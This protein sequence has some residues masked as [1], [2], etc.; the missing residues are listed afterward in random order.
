MAA[1]T[2]DV[3]VL[4]AGPGGYVA[5]I[6]AAQLGLKVAC[7]EA[8]KLGGVCNNLGCIP[9]K[10]LLESAMYARR[11]HELGDFGIRVSEVSLDLGAAGK[12]AKKVA[13][14]G[15]KGVAFLFKKNNVEWVKGWGRLA[16]KGKVSVKGSDGE[17]T[18]EAKNIILATGSRPKD[19][20]ILKADGD[21]V[22]NSD[23]AVFPAGAP[24]SLAVIGGGAVG[25]EFADVYA[26]FGTK[27]TVIEAL[28]RV[29]PLEDKDA[30]AAVA[31]SY[32]K[33]GMDVLEGARLE[34][35]DVGKA[36]VKL[37]VKAKDGKTNTIEVER[38]L[39]AV[40]RAPIIEDIG[41]ESAGV[42]VDKGFIAV[43]AQLRTSAPGIFAIGDVAR[44]PLL[45]H[46]ASHEGIAVVETIAGHAHVVDTNN[47]PNVTYCHPEVASVGLTED[48][49]RAQGLEVEI[50]VFPFSANG[51]ARTAGESE[52]FVKV[53]RDR[54]Y[55]ELLG[56]HIVGPH[57][58][59][60]IAEFVLGR[61][62]ESTAEELERAMHPHPTLSEAVAEAALAALGRAI[63][64]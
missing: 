15:A 22:W 50:G 40:G 20:P 63:H 14:Q 19:L 13:D 55:S 35:A 56:A 21:R 54:R 26:S 18:L 36:G 5:A 23:H 12:R 43:D 28:E 32:R 53:V 1:N 8:D 64:I 9:T 58:S 41:L 29:L 48:A 17:R 44:P 25:M 62:L 30:S 42:R 59:E 61:H 27:V 60:L 47:I 16:G 52:G 7:V 34:K 38:V 49:A 46:K 37:V 24:A 2:F 11:V 10:A 45:A 57:A 31:K 51:R 6:R 4:G 39:V 3:V 33:R